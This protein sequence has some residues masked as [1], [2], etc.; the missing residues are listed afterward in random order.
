MD[1]TLKTWVQIEWNPVFKNIDESYF[2]FKF[3]KKIIFLPLNVLKTT[4]K[5]APVDKIKS[6]LYKSGLSF[7]IGGLV[8][9]LCP[10][11]TKTGPKPD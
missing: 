11:L 3:F 5:H 6:F 10:N 8:Y 9:E 7:S 4:W 2:S 1:F